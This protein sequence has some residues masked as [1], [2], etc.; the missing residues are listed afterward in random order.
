[1][2]KVQNRQFESAGWL[3][4]GVGVAIFIG[5]AIYYA[6][7]IQIPGTSIFISIALGTTVAVLLSGVITASVNAF[8]QRAAQKRRAV[9]RRKTRK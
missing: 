2:A 7:S 4:W 8:L 9:E 5:P 3:F 6:H 1:M